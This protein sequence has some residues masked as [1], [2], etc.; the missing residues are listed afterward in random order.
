MKRYEE[1]SL[2]CQQFCQDHQLS[3]PQFKYHRKKLKRKQ[4][5]AQPSLIPITLKAEPTVPTMTTTNEPWPE[6]VFQVT[7]NNGIHCFIPAQ[8][9]AVSL[10]RLIEVLYTC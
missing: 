8:F 1:S 7:L 2:T 10:K 4:R 3:L 5:Q 9:E 6:A